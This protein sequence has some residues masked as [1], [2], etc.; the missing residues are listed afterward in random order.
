MIKYYD[1]IE[2]GGNYILFFGVGLTVF[3]L[4]GLLWVYLKVNE[5]KRVNIYRAGIL[6]VLSFV[7]TFIIWMSSTQ[8]YF[9]AKAALRNGAYSVVEGR[10]E[11]FSPIP[12][13]AH[14]DESFSV[15]G[16]PFK[17]SESKIDFGFNQSRINGS[18]VYQGKLVK[19]HYYEGRIL[20]LWVCDSCPFN[21]EGVEWK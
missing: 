21:P 12:M 16:I 19:I 3:I 6:C 10:V 11:H 7:W 2:N 20:R 15:K 4:T 18:P 1:L 8:D 5:K 17:Y 9:M 14:G 13:G